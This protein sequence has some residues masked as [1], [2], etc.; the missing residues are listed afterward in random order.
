MTVQA[1]E[2]GDVATDEPEQGGMRLSD[3]DER[4]EQILAD[5]TGTSPASTE[6]YKT[7]QKRVP[8]MGLF[9]GAAVVLALGGGGI[10]FWKK[11][12]RLFRF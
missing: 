2:Q 7:P 11:G 10:L 5:E 4:V 8:G 3:D 1:K 6:Q 12:K 9:L